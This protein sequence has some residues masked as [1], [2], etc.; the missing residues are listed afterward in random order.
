MILPRP[1]WRR[2]RAW[3]TSRR[4]TQDFV[5]NIRLSTE[6]RHGEDGDDDD[7]YDDCDED[8]YY[9]GDGGDY[10]DGDDNYYDDFDDYDDDNFH[11]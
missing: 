4:R 1:P 10:Y 3:R 6:H 9:D 11:G 8:Y 7:Y 5:G 2:G